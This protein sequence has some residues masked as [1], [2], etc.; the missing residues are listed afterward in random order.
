MELGEQLLDA[1][2][3]GES[4]SASGDGS[5]DGS[6]T[7]SIL[8]PMSARVGTGAAS[9]RTRDTHHGR[10][11][12]TRAL[13]FSGNALNSLRSKCWV[14]TAWG[15]NRPRLVPG[16]DYICGQRERCPRTG[17]PHWQMYIETTDRIRGS[18]LLALFADAATNPDWVLRTHGASNLSA[19]FIPSAPSSDDTV[20]SMWLEPRR[21]TQ[22]EAILYT[23][24][25]NLEFPGTWMEEGVMHDEPVSGGWGALQRAIREGASLEELYDRH[26]RLMAVY[27]KG[28][29]VAAQYAKGPVPME[30]N[31]QC[32]CFFGPTGSGKSSKVRKLFPH[33]DIYNRPDGPKWFDMYFGQKV[34]LFDDFAGSMPII[35]CLRILDRWR[36]LVETKGGHVEA[37]WE[38]VFFT[39]NRHPRHWFK[40]AHPDH[41]AAFY[42]RLPPEHILLINHPP[43]HPNRWEPGVPRPDVV[44]EDIE[45]LASL[46]SSA[47]SVRDLPAWD[48]EVAPIDARLFGDSA[49]FVL[50]ASPAGHRRGRDAA[51]SESSAT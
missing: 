21:G 42:R 40:G 46:A 49:P 8:M 4:Q 37:R 3:A 15:P 41:L 47:S 5:G 10:V 17:R 43:G 2:T 31:I 22:D 32:Y 27:G 29:I 19:V 25:A 51:A 34:L 13:G 16:V 14:A 39:S 36:M 9:Q 12:A 20:M 23:K 35:D 30:R 44:E 45:G 38:W 24:K 28:I 50:G 1:L 33:A 48:A 11:L 6:D 26:F 18:S 7:A